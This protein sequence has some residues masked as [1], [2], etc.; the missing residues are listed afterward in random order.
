M[1]ARYFLFHDAE[2]DQDFVV[3]A[4]DEMGAWRC[5]FED[6]PVWADAQVTFIG[7]VSY[8]EQKGMK[9]YY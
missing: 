5:L 7:E 1:T 9:Q 2:H 6:D 3:W 4:H 8:E